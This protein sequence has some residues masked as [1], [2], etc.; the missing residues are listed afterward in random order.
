MEA[1]FQERQKDKPQCTSTYQVFTYIPFACPIAKTSHLAKPR[2][3][4][5]DT[6]KDVEIERQKRS[7]DQAIIT[8]PQPSC[9]IQFSDELRVIWKLSCHHEP[10][11]ET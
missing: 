4:M 9:L 8:P 1:G 2:V 6:P 3:D 11:S 5:E 10:V 7:W